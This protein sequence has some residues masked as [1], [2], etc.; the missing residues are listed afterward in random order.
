[1]KAHDASPTPL[2]LRFGPIVSQAVDTQN[3]TGF[4]GRIV[5]CE[6]RGPDEELLSAFARGA[7][8]QEIQEILARQGFVRL[9]NDGMEKV[10]GGLTA[11]GEVF[12]VTA[13]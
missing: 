1:M 5:I 8:L 4:A 3:G 11:A 9:R 13:M 7:N 2:D 12:Y 10:R 6:L